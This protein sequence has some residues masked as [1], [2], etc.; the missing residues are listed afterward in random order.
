MEEKKIFTTGKKEFEVPP[1]DDTMKL[2]DV[3]IIWNN[4]KTVY[5]G[6]YISIWKNYA[7]Y[8][9]DRLQFINDWQTNIKSG[10]TLYY[11][12]STYWTISDAE[13]AYRIAGRNLNDQDTAGYV[14]DWIEW[15]HT[16]ADSDTAFWDAVKETILFGTWFFKVWYRFFERAFEYLEKTGK[17]A[18]GMEVVDNSTLEFISAMEMCVDNSA[19]S[20]EECRYKIRRR[21]MATKDIENT[22]S[23]YGLK[24]LKDTIENPF[25]VDQIDY[26]RFKKDI[27]MMSNI[28]ELRPIRDEV[29]Y[30]VPEKNS[31]VFEVY[32]RDKVSIFVNGVKYGPFAQIG[33]RRKDP[34]K[35]MQFIRIPNSLYGLG[36]GTIVKP[37]QEVFDGMLNSRMDNVKLVNNKVFIHVTSKDPMLQGQDYIEL[38]PWLIIHTANP[39]ALTEMKIDDIKQ[40]PI[41]ESQN[42]MDLTDKAIGTNG[43]NLWVQNKVER[44]SWAMD[45]LQRASLGRIRGCIKSVGNAMWFSAKYMFILSLYYTDKDIFKKVLGDEWYNK[46]MEISIEDAI[47]DID[48]EFNMDADKIKSIS[49][50]MQQGISL[51]QTLPALKD[52]GGNP[53]V[54][55]IPIVDMI[56]RGM[57]MGESVKLTDD[58]IKV[59]AEKSATIKKTFDEAAQ[60]IAPQQPAVPQEQSQPEATSQPVAAT[61]TDQW[62][63]NPIMQWLW[64]WQ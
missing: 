33:P 38:E 62:Q 43:Y 6:Y 17:T 18:K 32:E 64:M 16:R 11:T 8:G 15:L 63:A 56:L 53:I 49:Q 42:L 58:D 14:L 45:A 1:T 2:N 44:V 3:R 13:Q 25:Y 37:S 10:M 27:L 4:Y 51:L 41:I 31:E 23:F 28:A 21:V 20:E 59:A 46:I 19:R 9:W 55:P 61:P 24:L 30:F 50:K 60:S 40:W 7:M 34:I 54:D 52:A 39:D 36:I 47:N 12:E 35:A 22:Y 26:E 48:F 29:F 5:L 57:S